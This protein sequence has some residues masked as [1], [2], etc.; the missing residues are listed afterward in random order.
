LFADFFV[1]GNSR[2]PGD[3]S[4]EQNLPPNHWEERRLLAKKVVFLLA[5]A[6]LGGNTLAGPIMAD[7]LCSLRFEFPPF[8]FFLFPF[9]FVDE[10]ITQNSVKLR[11][12]TLE[13]VLLGHV[14]CGKSTLLGSQS[15]SS[16]LLL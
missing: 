4:R 16:F 1:S 13:M 3:V 14:D 9:P 12:Q 5:M 7:H 6:A 15:L 11:R 2:A 8:F 10:E